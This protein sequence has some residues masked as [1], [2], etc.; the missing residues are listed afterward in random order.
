MTGALPTVERPSDAWL[1]LAVV[2]EY[3]YQL[4]AVE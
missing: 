2:V 1:R 4:E 3:V